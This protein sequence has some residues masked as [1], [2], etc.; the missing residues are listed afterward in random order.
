MENGKP[1]LKE[2]KL[3]NTALF[4]LIIRDCEED[5]F[6]SKLDW[7]WFSNM[8]YLRKPIKTHA[9]VTKWNSGIYDI[10]GDR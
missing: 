2:D 5:A 1:E 10:Q 8:F 7:V 6:T 4:F 9:A 3:K